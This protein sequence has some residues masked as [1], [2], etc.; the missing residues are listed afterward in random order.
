MTAVDNTKSKCRLQGRY[1][2]E[3]LK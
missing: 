2:I 1:K 3:Y